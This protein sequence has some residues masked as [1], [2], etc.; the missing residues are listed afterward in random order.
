MK[1]CTSSQNWKKKEKYRG[2]FAGECN[3][4]VK[5]IIYSSLIRNRNLLLDLIKIKGGDPK[6]GKGH[7]LLHLSQVMRGSSRDSLQCGYLKNDRVCLELHERK[8]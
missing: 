8:E 6:I 5:F 2:E 3:E 4:T 1:E 7:V